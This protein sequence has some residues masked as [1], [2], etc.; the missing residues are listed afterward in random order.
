MTPTTGQF[1][2]L[3]GPDGC[4][5]STQTRLLAQWLAGRGCEVASYR[6]P[7]TTVIGEKIRDILLDPSHT[8][9]KDNVEVLL[10]MAARAQL[11]AEHIGPDLEHGRFVVMDRW[12][13]ST[14]AYQG[15]AGGFGM[16]KVLTIAEAALERVW[17]D[18]TI[19]LDVDLETALNRMNRELDRMEQKGEEYHRR[20]REGFLAIPSRCP[21]ATIID[22][23][24]SV[25]AVH[26]AVIEYLKTV[27]GWHKT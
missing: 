2:V 20:V 12:L 8:A 16:E 4:G 1:I 23:R 26:H 27:F 6:D 5:K 10:Y 14:C 19:I 11:W 3:D 17:P 18:A 21:N 22:A 13:S 9:M 15:Y 24:L 25:E 7:G